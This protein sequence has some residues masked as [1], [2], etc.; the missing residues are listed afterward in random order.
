[1][2]KG[3][4][5]ADLISAAKQLAN[6]K[7]TIVGDGPEREHLEQMAKGLP[8]RFIGRVRHDKVADY[9][10]NARVLVLPSHVGDGLPN[11]ILEAMSLGVP[12]I[13]TR[14]A[15]IP[16]VVLHQ[17][18]GLLCEPG[19]VDQLASHIHLLSENDQ[20][21]SKMSD[22]ASSVAQSYSWN[23]VTPRIESVLQAAIDQHS[24]RREVLTSGAINVENS[25]KN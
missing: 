3:K 22:Q 19:D 20:L 6:I 11:V 17:D 25:S 24:S 15:G 7:F 9:L 16:D 13:S 5:T 18:T 8:I 23:V 10:R 4:G 12:V 1:L 21:H 14:T 2:I